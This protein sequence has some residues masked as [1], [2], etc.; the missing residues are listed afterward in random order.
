V[1]E[2]FTP[3]VGV[4]GMLQSI[5]DEANLSENALGLDDIGVI[6]ECVHSQV[7]FDAMNAL[8][9]LLGPSVARRLRFVAHQVSENTA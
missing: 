8:Y 9:E 5:E 4:V 7:S 3:C 1:G 6:Y 2:H